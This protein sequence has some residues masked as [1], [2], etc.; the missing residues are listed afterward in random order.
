MKKFDKIIFKEFKS[1]FGRFFAIMAIIALGVGFLIGIMQATPDMK[2]TM[3]DYL[4]TENAFD[5]D[6]K[7]SFGLSSSDLGALAALGGV[8]SVMPVISTDAVVHTG[9]KYVVGRIVGMENVSSRSNISR[10]TLLEGEWPG[11]A[12]EGVA[13]VVALRSTNKLEALSVGEEITL[14]ADMST[15][16]TSY[17]DVYRVHTLRVTGIVSSPDY[18]YDDA[19][20]IST[21]GTG[22]VGCILYGN[23]AEV[24]EDLSA[25][26]S[27]T[28]IK[29]GSANIFGGINF[30]MDGEGADHIA[31]TDAYIRIEGADGY[32]RFNDGYKNYGL[33]RESAI[34]ELGAR[35]SER[36]NAALE[37]LFATQ[38][39][40]DSRRTEAS[41]I[42]LDR[43][44]TNVSYLSYELNVEKVEDIA[45]I[46]PVFFIFVAALVALTSMTR[47]VEEDR[48]QIGTLKALGYSNARIRSKYLFY[49][50]LASLIGCVAGILLGFSIL[51][52]IFWEAYKTLYY[53]PSLSL[54]FSPWFALAVIGIAL[55]GTVLVT[56]GACR[57]SLK[58]RP[59]RL[60]QP[61]APKAG[62]RVLLERIGFLWKPLKFKWKATVRNIFRYKKNMILTIVSVM[63][64][65]ALILVGFGLNDSIL[66]ASDIQYG[67]IIHYDSVIGYAGDLGEIRAVEGGSLDPFLTEADDWIPIYS[68]SGQIEL[69]TG[70]DK[71][72]TESV[73]LY[74]IE[75]NALFSEFV[76]LHERRSGEQIDVTQAEGIAVVLPENLATVYGVKAGDSLIYTTAGGV[77]FVAR[78]YAIC[79]NYTGSYLYM[80]RTAYASVCGEP[81]NNTLLVRSGLSQEQ[82]EEASEALLADKSGRITSVEFIY[83]TMEIFDGL[84]STMGLVI[85]VLVVCAG[86]L[87]AIVLYNLTNINIDERRREIATL[88]VLGY[89]KGEVA[90]YI[91]RES[92]ILTLAGTLFGLLLGWLLHMFIIGRVNSVSMMLGTTIGALSY[93]WAFLLTIAFA[94]IV[95]LFMLIKL[96]RISM[97][98]SLKSNE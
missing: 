33:S 2:R 93:L 44:S 72:G 63:G 71:E 5:I 14:P 53:L 24:Y 98:D 54:A 35:S 11:E 48:M 55:A 76:S 65:T 36:I 69:R 28:E 80:S 66:A 61:K 39:S 40:S 81:E 50:C 19:T 31:C 27:M 84:E 88:R 74:L 12:E 49:C 38:D 73:D 96:N 32:E 77:R 78:V 57:A 13:E 92:A 83:S 17:G 6:L 51:P 79:E 10:L 8:E 86:A 75:D 20:E 85:A 87:A 7:G 59:S 4:Q 95:Y 18:F 43:A 58:E 16:N 21:L 91:Y 25:V 82:S 9:E 70:T 1:G 68:E 67:D 37:K 23:S 45:G 46:F 29:L 56:W 42:L 47:M 22:A 15:S 64:C 34:L 41:W 30:F 52:S 3:D 97:T 62:K 60:M 94:V 89:R 26:P 90:G